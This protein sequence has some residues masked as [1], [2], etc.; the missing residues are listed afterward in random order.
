MGSG[1]DLC[2]WTASIASV[3]FGWQYPPDTTGSPYLSIMLATGW[4]ENLSLV[5]MQ[6]V[7]AAW[8][9][10]LG[11][12][13]GSF[14]NVVIF[15]LPAGLSLQTPKSRC[16][17]C[18]TQLA[19]KDNI[20][21]FGWLFLKGRC[22]YCG[23]PISARYPVI[24]FVC[25]AVFLILM[26]AELVTGAANLPLQDAA[27]VTARSGYWLIWFGQ[28]EV[29]A[30]WLYHCCLLIIVLAIAMIGYDGH[31]PHKKLILFALAVAVT[32]CTLIPAVQPVPALPWPAWM[33]DLRWGFAW[34]DVL[35]R[36]GRMYWTG[37]SLTGFLNSSAGILAGWL[38]GRL[39]AFELRDP[40]SNSLSPVS[41]A[42]CAAVLV[43]G[44]FLG[45]HACGML[46]LVIVPLLAVIHRVHPKGTSSA[47][48]RWTAPAYFA[49]VLL[50]LLTWRQLDKA[51]WMIGHRGWT[52]TPFGWHYDWLGTA[53]LLVAFVLLV[54]YRFHQ[55]FGH[56]DDP[57][58]D[59]INHN[60][61]Q[62][63]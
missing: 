24:E 13:F 51:V 36:S 15:R 17:R 7:I 22:R 44:A 37:I 5:L 62:E 20:P 55:S 60:D 39:I 43:T 14:L 4:E 8:V 53:A 59:L 48:P 27:S 2:R 12:C 47:I 52:F 54:R 42:L 50:F 46:T 1:W 38:A 10:A 18:E 25:G 9:F 28:W 6:A 41:G 31:P 63:T 29:T 61:N 26:L 34:K 30:T 21:V 3:S 19:A 16:P 40:R 33:T 58:T 57:L 45:W 23:L 32:G 56:P 49:L 11:A 35:F